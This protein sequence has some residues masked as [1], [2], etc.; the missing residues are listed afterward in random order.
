[1]HEKAKELRKLL[2][3]SRCSTQGPLHEDIVQLEALMGRQRDRKRL[4]I[5]DPS[6]HVEFR[7]PVSIL[8][9]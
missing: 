3:R 2:R 4:R 9:A 1:M 7:V 6:Q 5:N 8:F